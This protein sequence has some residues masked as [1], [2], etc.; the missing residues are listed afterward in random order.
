MAL[1]LARRGD[2]WFVCAPDH[3][4]GDTVHRSDPTNWPATPVL[5]GFDRKTDDPQGSGPVFLRE[6]DVFVAP[7]AEFDNIENIKK[8][9][10]KW[11]QG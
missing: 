11:A 8:A 6:R 9:G 10:S 1:P 4:P 5:F 2:W 7:E 3:S